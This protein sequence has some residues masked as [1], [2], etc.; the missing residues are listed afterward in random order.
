MY[1]VRTLL[2]VDDQFQ[3]KRIP[4]CSEIGLSNGGHNINILQ[5]IKNISFYFVST[6]SI[7]HR[8]SVE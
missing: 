3:E 2:C 8:A 4:A 5:N 7:Y 1:L 6:S